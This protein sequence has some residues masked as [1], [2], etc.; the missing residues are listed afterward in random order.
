M[1]YF[2]TNTILSAYPF[3]FSYS[4]FFITYQH[5][6]TQWLNRAGEVVYR[7]PPPKCQH[8]FYIF[9]MFLCGYFLIDC[10][11]LHNLIYFFQNQSSFSFKSANLKTIHL[12]AIPQSVILY[13]IYKNFSAVSAHIFDSAD[14]GRFLPFLYDT[15]L[16]IRLVFC[17]E[18]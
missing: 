3:I 8:Y 7:T 9:F 5:N 13:Y 4:L 15:I 6:L 16:F 10:Y 2:P 1:S 12:S 18:N 14:R 11:Y 17:L